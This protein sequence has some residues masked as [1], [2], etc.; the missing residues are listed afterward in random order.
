MQC[1]AAS[2][3]ELFKASGEWSEAGRSGPPVNQAEPGFVRQ[4]GRPTSR[5]APVETRGHNQESAAL[6]LYHFNFKTEKTNCFLIFNTKNGNFLF[7]HF[8]PQMLLKRVI[9]VVNSIWLSGSPHG[10]ILSV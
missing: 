8:W 3:G 6:S 5:P 10:T 4:P 1:S 9:G 2:L 7:N